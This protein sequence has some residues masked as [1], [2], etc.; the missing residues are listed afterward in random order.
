MFR[1]KCLEDAGYFDEEMR[2]HADGNLWFRMLKYHDFGHVPVPLLKYRWHDTN[3]SHHFRGMRRYLDRYYRKILDAYSCEEIYP[4][5]GEPGDAQLALGEILL[6]RHRL[7]PLGFSLLGE[8]VRRNP[9]RA[10]GYGRMLSCSLRMPWYLLS[11]VY[12]WR[13]S[14]RKRG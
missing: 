8:G 7:Y 3:I 1:R 13:L 11:D 12:S 5:G 6:R 14:S 2:Y 10:R 4:D 9:F